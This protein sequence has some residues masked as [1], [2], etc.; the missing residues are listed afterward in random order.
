MKSL[1]EKDRKKN[2]EEI[3]GLKP[4][5]RPLFMRRRKIHQRSQ[6]RSSCKVREKLKCGAPKIQQKK[7][8]SAEG[9]AKCT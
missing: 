3:Q 4:W 1:R 9:V 7:A 2:E 8:I 6:Q 5:E